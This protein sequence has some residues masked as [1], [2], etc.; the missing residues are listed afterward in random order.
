MAFS[1]Q[2]GVDITAARRLHQ[3]LMT[4]DEWLGRDSGAWAR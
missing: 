4:F 1:V 2:H 3:G